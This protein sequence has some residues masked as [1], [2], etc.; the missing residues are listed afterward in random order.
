MKT[1]KL[2]SLGLLVWGFSSCDDGLDRDVSVA[3]VTVTPNENVVC[4]GVTV[5]VKK[6]E[7]IVFNF[8]GEPDNIVFFSGEKGKTYDFRNRTTEDISQIESSKLTFT[9]D[10]NYGYGNA[11]SYSNVLHM[12]ISTD[13]SGLYKNDFEADKKMV[14]EFQWSDLVSVDDLP[15]NIQQTHD[16]EV[17]M[18][19]YLGKDITL[20]ISYK[21]QD[22]AN[23]QGRYN[24]TNMKITNVYKD[25]TVIEVPAAEF[26]FTALNISPEYPDS[27]QLK[28]L[29]YQTSLWDSENN[30]I[31]A[32][33]QY[34]TV[35]VGY[36]VA[37][38]WNTSGLSTSDKFYI[39]ASSRN[40]SVSDVTLKNTWLVS[41]YIVVNSCS[42][43]QGVT[44]KN[45]ANR[46]ASYEY[47]YNEVG[48]YKATF[49]MTNSNY[50]HEDSKV[51]T[52]IINVK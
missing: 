45:M 16:Y 23:I 41:D 33:Y 24:F 20:A 36:D 18:T 52:M 6:G 19:P 47:T 40:T 51:V 43:D 14:E 44:I 29:K 10:T 4:E 38:M 3:G 28:N 22:L 27:E 8:S 42:P 25:G 17:D 26:G 15:T 5:N 32:N 39:H 21:G 12:Y 2:L 1:Y 48:T 34:A 49:L 11:T 50:K 9:I 35:T 46:L 7:P 30:L 31:V 37:G 13:F